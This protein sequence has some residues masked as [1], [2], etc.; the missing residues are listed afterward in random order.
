MDLTEAIEAALGK[1]VAQFAS[2]DVPRMAAMM[3]DVARASAEYAAAAAQSDTP[4]ERLEV[5]RGN[6]V[7]ATVLLAQATE[8][9]LRAR[10]VDAARTVAG[11]AVGMAL[12]VFLQAR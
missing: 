8:S 2:Q 11:Y 1:A 10:G 3:A 7:T 6:V 9:A 5:L 12:R 4:K